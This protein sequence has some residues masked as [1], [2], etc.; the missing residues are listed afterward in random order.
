M[1]LLK[2]RNLWSNTEKLGC[3][4]RA[5]ITMQLCPLTS[6]LMSG[7]FVLIRDA[8]SEVLLSG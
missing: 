7:A 3:K 6:R 2:R 4:F 8:P 5:S 1:L